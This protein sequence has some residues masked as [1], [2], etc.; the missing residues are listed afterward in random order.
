MMQPHSRR[1][2]MRGPL[3]FIFL[4]MTFM[5]GCGPKNAP[6][7]STVALQSYVGE[8]KRPSS[9]ETSAEGSLWSNQGRRS[10]LF[11]DPKA[12]FVN[13]IVIIHVVE[14][15]QASS[16]ADAKNSK[17]TSATAAVDSL[18]GLQKKVK[19]LPTLAGATTTGAYEGK[20]STTRA[21]SVTTDVA[22]RV[23]DV[24]PNGYLVVDAVK[25][26]RLNNENQSIH[27]TG[28]VRPEDISRGNI[29]LSSAVSQ[30]TV[31]LHGKGVVSQSLS[32]GFL[33][34]LLTSILPF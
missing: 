18:F 3:T 34:K 9:L 32:P 22:A 26:I 8:A 14:S 5:A 29:V 10:D 19:E 15:T 31:Q 20:G 11:R 16:T 27:V 2:S 6:I 23:V 7:G 33:Y 25:D 28:V 30:M 4:A 17:N 24:L 12:R 1:S 21:T 13:D